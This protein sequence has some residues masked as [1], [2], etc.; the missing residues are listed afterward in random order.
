MYFLYE[1]NCTHNSGNLYKRVNGRTFYMIETLYIKRFIYIYIYIYIY[2]G[3]RIAE[4]IPYGY[5]YIYTSILL[6]GDHNYGVY[7][8]F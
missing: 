5:I 8:K 1:K 6:R 2:L 7:V 4:A 3:T